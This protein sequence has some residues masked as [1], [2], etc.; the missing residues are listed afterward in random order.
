MELRHLRYFVAA[1]EEIHFSRAAERLHVSAPAVG[2][3]IKELE[4]ELGVELF[5]RLA[6][7]VKL[8]PAGAAFLEGVRTVLGHLRTVVEQTQEV[9][10]GKVGVLRVGHAAMTIRRTWVGSVIPTFCMRYPHVDVRTNDLNT[11][12]QYQALAQDRIDVGIVYAPPDAA[13][14][15]AYELLEDNLIEGVL[16]PA[17]HPLAKK[18]PLYARDLAPLPFL[19]PQGASNPRSYD[20]F[21][22]NLRAR[23]LDPRCHEQQIS[24]PDVLVHL[25]ASGAGWMPANDISAKVL[26]AGPSGVAYRKW[27]DPPFSLPMCVVWRNDDRSPLVTNFVNLC[28]ELRD[29]A[30]RNRPMAR[31]PAA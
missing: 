23:G 3:Q 2:Q 28:R 26:L 4:D 15:L 9:G 24:D 13:E 17:S 6:R 8:T 18:Q 27:A 14:G 7:G 29:V 21:I 11:V 1:A 12:E 22:K 10:R 30:R 16:L 20:E 19:M 31:G 25:V 5:E